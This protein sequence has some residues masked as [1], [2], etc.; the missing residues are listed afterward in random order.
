MGG[1]GLTGMRERV[2]MFGGLLD[3]GVTE[4]GGFLVRAELP[5]PVLAAVT[6]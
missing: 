3:A 5:L 1:H 6:A 4:G 2:A